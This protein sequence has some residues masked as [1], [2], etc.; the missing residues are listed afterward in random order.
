[1]SQIFSGPWDSNVHF[2]EMFETPIFTTTV[3][4]NPTGFNTY[5]GIKM[6]FD[7]LGCVPEIPRESMTSC[8][9]IN[10]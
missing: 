9:Y 10:T 2:T 7:V 6:T 5:T 1:M 8:V 4:I 3:R